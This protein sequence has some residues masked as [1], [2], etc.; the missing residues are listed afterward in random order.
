ME[1]LENTNS[2]A[3]QILERR[4]MPRCAVDAD[5]TLLL[6]SVDAT[7]PCRV[8][9]LGL[10]GCRL[11]LRQK[12]PPEVHA[13]VEVIFK[14]RGIVFRLSG[15]TEWSS[16]GNLVGMSFGTMSTRRRDDLMEVLCE[17]EAENAAKAEEQAAGDASD[18]GA[19]PA[20]AGSASETVATRAKEQAA[21]EGQRS[22]SFPQGEGRK[23]RLLDLVFRRARSADLPPEKGDG[24]QAGG[25]DTNPEAARDGS[26]T[27]LGPVLVART[28]FPLNVGAVAEPSASGSLPQVSE[29]IVE[30]EA[31]ALTGRERRVN[32]RCDIDTTAVIHLVKIR[33]KLSGHVVDLSQGGC[34]IRTDERFP[35][36]IYT[37]VEVEFR[38]QGTP[39]LLG[40]VIQTIH[41]RHHV[42]IR[43]LDVSPRKHA[44]LA[45]LM[46]EIQEIRGRE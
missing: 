17:V 36:G 29:S 40:G 23:F 34:R 27:R 14:I 39:L 5:A 20:S 24:T 32:H 43:F 41:D 10:G 9:E 1:E 11:V 16:G 42:G 28:P 30:K 38:V 22:I 4:G 35:V 12:L 37:R 44:Q 45:E 15:M 8:V 18:R 33:S 26:P 2:L 13:V 6:L 25:R 21:G 3:A 19:E 46:D 31:S 7:I